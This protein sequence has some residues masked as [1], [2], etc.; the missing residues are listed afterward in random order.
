V[1]RITVFGAGA[2]GT[3][4]AIHLARKGQEATLWGSKY[5]QAVLEELMDRRSHPAL[6]E[7]LPAELRILGA[8]D[9]DDA[10]KGADLGVLAA[11]SRGGRSL[12]QMVA[13]AL[14]SDIGLVS[15]T[16]GLEPETY[17]RMSEVYGEETKKAVVAV[18]GPML[19][20]ELA[21]GWLT[22]VVFASEDADLLERAAETFRS[23]TFVVEVTDDVLGTE[24]CGTA[25][26][27][28]AIG[29]GVLE[30]LAESR[31]RDLKN[32]RAALFT[33]AIGEIADLVEALGGR[34]ETAFGLAGAG[35]LLVTSLG[36]RNRA[37][38]HAIGLGG[39][40]EHTLEDMTAQGMTVEGAGSAAEVH[41]LA[42]REGL[43]LP[44]HETVYGVV[45]EGASPKTILEA[46]G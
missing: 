45:H 39:E 15:I 29:A 30:G 8:D 21:E 32:A 43:A 7:R 13:P 20:P 35:D 22:A 41:H 5:D 40:P 10:T 14:P 16:K 25:K 1:T 36:G 3:A 28:A 24:I 26:N 31:Q 23:D 12:A 9:L 27:V 33:R 38:G 34:R 46:I 37:Y 17:A 18:S 11:N 2:A 4:V 42:E 44:I 19:A 6:P